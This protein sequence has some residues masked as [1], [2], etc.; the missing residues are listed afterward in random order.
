[1]SRLKK[2]LNASKRLT[3][4][5]P[6]NPKMLKK[7]ALAIVIT[8]VAA[9]LYLTQVVHHTPA[10]KDRIKLQD[11]VKQLE[12]SKKTLEQTKADTTAQ[13]AAKQQQ[14]NELNKQLQDTKQQLEAKRNTPKVYAE[15]APAQTVAPTPPASTPQGDKYT[16]MA[17]AG[18]PESD[19][20]YVDYIV[21]RE[22]SWNP[23]AV[24]RNGGACGLVQALP[25][26][27]LGANWNDP[28][29]ALKWQYNYVKARY[30]GYAGAYAFWV[31]NHWY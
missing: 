9:T 25:C 5:K 1:M 20:K 12:T 30:G 8:L 15:E 13:D 18:I 2:G 31:S 16:W 14:I 3:L 19:W 11:T 7:L 21:S 17:Q 29:T 23:N 10:Y 28:V 26:S 6:K 27:K 24:N 4:K 22:S